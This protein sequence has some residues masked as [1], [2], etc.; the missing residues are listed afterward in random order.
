[1]G[2]FQ[3]VGAVLAANALTIL[4]VYVLWRVGRREAIGGEASAFQLIIAAAAPLIMAYG[5]WVMD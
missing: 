5:F 1:M 4:W 3:V 2:M